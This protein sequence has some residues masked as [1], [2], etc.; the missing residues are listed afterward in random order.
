MPI[1]DHS[2]DANAKSL[3]LKANGNYISL[4]KSMQRTQTRKGL[5]SSSDEQFSAK[6]KDISNAKLTFSA[7]RRTAEKAEGCK[8]THTAV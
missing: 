6:N 5:M 4:H 1:R 7:D 3:K 2:Y 8:Q